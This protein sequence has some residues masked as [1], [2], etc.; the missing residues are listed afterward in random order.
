MR[1]AVLALVPIGSSL[2]SAQV[3]LRH[4]GFACTPQRGRIAGRPTSDYLLCG[5]SV[6]AGSPV[7]RKWLV[8][9]FVDSGRVRDVATNTG[10]VG[11]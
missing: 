9:L 3:R 8:V 7:A 5:A 11:P 10:L 6:S 1:S 2:D 4:E